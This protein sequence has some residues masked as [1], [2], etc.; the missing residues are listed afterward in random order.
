MPQRN[1]PFDLYINSKRCPLFYRD[2]VAG[3]FVYTFLGK[4][5]TR[6]QTE[7]IMSHPSNIRRWVVHVTPLTTL[8]PICYDFASNDKQTN[9]QTINMHRFVYGM[10]RVRE[11]ERE[12]VRELFKRIVTVCVSVYVQ[13][14]S[15]IPFDRMRTNQYINFRPSNDAFF[16]F[17]CIGS[18]QKMFR[19][20]VCMLMLMLAFSPYRFIKCILHQR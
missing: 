10:K 16:S 13:C 2:L 18:S 11:R 6:D 1:Q 7:N 5:W 14:E 8:K 17:L 12:G 19:V 9:N 3:E 4:K 20:C 15:G